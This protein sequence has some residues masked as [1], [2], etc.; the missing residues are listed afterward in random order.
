MTDMKADVLEVLVVDDELLSRSRLVALLSGEPNV[1]VVGECANG[2][3]A[4]AA[5]SDRQPDLVFLDVEMP[6]LDGMGVV[7]AL[8]D[9]QCP[10]II[11]V[12]AHSEYMER[13]FELHAVDYLRKP[14]TNSRFASAMAHARKRVDARR[15]DQVAASPSPAATSYAKVVA[16][17][18]RSQP[19]D[20]RLAV[21][22]RQTA[23]WHIIH[24]SEID[25][26]ESDGPSQVSVHV[27]ERTYAWRQTLS[28]L[29]ENLAPFGF[30]RVHRSF[31]VNS[32]RIRSVKSLLK[33]E[34]AL[35]L[36]DGKL[37]D[38]GRTYR[39]TIERFLDVHA[40]AP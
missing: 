38:T 23:T 1:H 9:D 22:D 37:L 39:D 13:A 24:R 14:Y 26:I 25:W 11:F 20:G 2:L 6:E 27:G 29:T 18:K 15:R 34:F 28:A 40:L 19:E 8:G 35:M 12:T 21:R 30:L 36:V 16:A 33:G 7:D 31:I 17:I 5:I 3:E 4:L 32:A 10:E